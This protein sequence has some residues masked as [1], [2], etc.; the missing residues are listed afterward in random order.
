MSYAAVSSSSIV[1][2]IIVAQHPVQEEQQQ[3]GHRQKG[4][5]RLPVSKASQ[6]RTPPHHQPAPSVARASGNST[7]QR[8][9]QVREEK[10]VAWVHLQY[11]GVPPHPVARKH[12]RPRQLRTR[13]MPIIRST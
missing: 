2:I 3:H 5:A 13:E 12:P 11:Q 10:D 8:D 6:Q 9:E 4:K 7:Q 1:T